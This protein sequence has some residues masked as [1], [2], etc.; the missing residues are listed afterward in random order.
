[1][2]RRRRKDLKQKEEGK[3]EN[4]QKHRK[5]RKKEHT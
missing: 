4:R 5:T 1:M 2:S 3:T